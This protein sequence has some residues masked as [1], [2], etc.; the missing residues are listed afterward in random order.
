MDKK[1][2]LH[3]G[4]GKTGT[5]FLQKN[6]FPFID[7]VFYAGVFARDNTV[8]QRISIL[9]HKYKMTYFDEEEVNNLKQ[10]VK[11]FIDELPTSGLIYSDESLVGSAKLSYENNSLINNYL[12]NFFS[13]PKIFVVFRQQGEWINSLYNQHIVK[14]NIFNKYVSLNEFIGYKDNNYTNDGYLKVQNLNWH[15]VICSYIKDFG[16]ENVLALPFE[17][18]VL[19]PKEF[20]DKFYEFSCFEPFYPASYKAENTRAD[21]IAKHFFALKAYQSSPRL[22][23]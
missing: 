6:V 14:S 7:E 18:F 3:V 9:L 4:F 20:L 8:L 11:Q 23:H 15:Q 5:T 12:K 22:E 17:L 21:T 1:I 16:N 10:K 2:I 19:N 13:E